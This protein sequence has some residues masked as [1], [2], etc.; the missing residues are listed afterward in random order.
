MLFAKWVS[1]NIGSTTQPIASSIANAN[2]MGFYVSNSDATGGTARGLY[3]RLYLTGT[4]GQSGEAVRAFTTVNGTGAV[5]VHGSQSSVSFGTSG[6]ITGLAAGIRSTFQVKN[7]TMSTGTATAVMSEL[8]A[9]GS[10]S[11]FTGTVLSFFRLAISGNSTG[12][13]QLNGDSFFMDLTGGCTA[14]SGATY[15]IDTS[16][17]ALTGYG[18]LRVKCPDGVTRYIPITTGS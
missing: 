13:T 11:H 14:G 9:D 5:G 7:A 2:F 12:I 15:F 4:S 17:T 8:S 3:M 16:K 1:D 10:S 18:S 6:T